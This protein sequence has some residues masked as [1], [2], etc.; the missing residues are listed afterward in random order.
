MPSACLLRNFER[1]AMPASIPRTLIKKYVK[2][3]AT[4]SCLCSGCVM[5]HHCVQQCVPVSVR[6]FSAGNSVCRTPGLEDLLGDFEWLTYDYYTK[7]QVAGEELQLTELGEASVLTNWTPGTVL[8]IILTGCV[9]YVYE[10]L[11]PLLTAPTQQRCA[12]GA[13]SKDRMYSIQ[14]WIA[15][16]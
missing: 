6:D 2:N 7:S 14:F 10:A 5:L 15:Y 16:S 12:T 3:L 8:E 9:V 11:Y 13:T 4:E 1:A